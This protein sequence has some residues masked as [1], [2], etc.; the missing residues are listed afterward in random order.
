M[1]I[2]KTSKG[3]FMRQPQSRRKTNLSLLALLGALSLGGLIACEGV[4]GE[5]GTGANDP[6]TVGKPGQPGQPGQPG[7]PG[8]VCV[9]DVCSESGSNYKGPGSVAM[10]RLNNTEYANTISDL[11]SVSQPSVTFPVEGRAQGYDTLSDALAVSPIHIEAYLD[12]ADEVVEELF[13]TDPG[14]VQT[15]W[16]DYQTGDAAVN[17]SCAQTI[18]A[19][20]AELAWRRSLVDWPDGEPTSGY[21]DLLSEGGKLA[22]FPLETRLRT[23]LAAVLVSPR[24]IYRVEFSDGAGNLDTP[25]L[26]SR[27]SYF[28]W[29]SAPDARLLGGDLQDAG[30]IETELAR[31]QSDERFDRFMHRFSDMWLELEKLSGIERDADLYPGFSADLVPA[32]IEETVGSFTNYFRSADA[33]LADFLTAT[34]TPP[35]SLQELYGDS[36]RRG[37]LTQ[38]SILTLTAVS[39]RTAPVKRG[40]YVLERILCAPPPPPP[41]AAIAMIR[42]DLENDETLTERERLA[43][44][45]ADPSCAGCHAMMDPIGLGFENYDAIGAYRVVDG[46]GTDVDATGV[47]PLADGGDVAFGDATELIDILAE[48]ERFPSCVARQLLTYGAGR[49]FESRSD[50]AL[51]EVVREFAGG[52]EATFQDMMRSV[53]LSDGFRRRQEDSL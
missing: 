13:A 44:H 5:G 14:G 39:N 51:I 36:P 16:C 20:F 9:G 43:L 4:L 38:A 41:E 26:A 3:V 24:F 47:L 35:A 32:M 7:E 10:R 17:E 27:L 37:L 29:S 25:S 42:E 1:S 30:Q 46:S 8:V 33:P 31:M 23:A 45:R 50:E 19:D 28:L 6:G 48:D 21:A 11:L 18:A 34:S 52:D 2:V 40:M 49:T 53:V 15:G 22:D 12:A